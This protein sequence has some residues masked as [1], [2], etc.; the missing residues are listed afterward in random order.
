MKASKIL[1]KALKQ[2]K[3]FNETWDDTKIKETEYYIKKLIAEFED[4]EH[5]QDQITYE[6]G[7]NGGHF[8]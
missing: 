2:I 6:S 4:H 7:L 3:R 5:F 8:W 1:K